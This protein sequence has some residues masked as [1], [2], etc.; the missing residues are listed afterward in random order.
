MQAK[1]D[2]KR[3]RLGH[4]MVHGKAIWKPG[5]GQIAKALRGISLGPHMGGLW[6]SIWAPSYKGQHADIHW[7]M[8]C[9]HTTQSLMKN[10]GQQK[11]LDKALHNT[12]Y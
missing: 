4:Q 6:H 1:R 5:I 12:V 3:E 2:L 11:W 9:G 8:A 10:R 7:V